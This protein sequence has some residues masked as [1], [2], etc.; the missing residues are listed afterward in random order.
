M[1]LWCSAMYVQVRVWLPH[2]PIVQFSECER[3]FRSIDPPVR[4][5][6]GHLQKIGRRFFMDT[7]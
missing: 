3:I 2:M 7:D 6:A 5:D 4:V 1:T